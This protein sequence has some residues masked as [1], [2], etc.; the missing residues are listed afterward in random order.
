MAVNPFFKP[1]FCDY[2]VYVQFLEIFCFFYKIQIFFIITF[3]LFPDDITFC[4]K[5]LF[6]GISVLLLY[7]TAVCNEKP[8]LSHY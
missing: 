6:K 1:I 3:F 7:Y 8:F 2:P 4:T 5:N